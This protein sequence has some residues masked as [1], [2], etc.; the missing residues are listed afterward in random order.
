MEIEGAGTA[1]EVMEKTLQDNLAKVTAGGVCDVFW[2]VLDSVLLNGPKK[3]WLSKLWKPAAAEGKVPYLV[4]AE[5]LVKTQI[6]FGSFAITPNLVDMAGQAV[7]QIESIIK[8]GANPEEVGIESVVSVNKI[9]NRSKAE[10]A[11][12]KLKNEN[13][14]GVKVLE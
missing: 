11:G 5:A 9:L 4:E 8:D 3:D 12:V 7:Q 1:P 13:L 14:S 10:A 6:D 2:M